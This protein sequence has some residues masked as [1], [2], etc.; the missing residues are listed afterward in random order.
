[1]T[2]IRDDSDLEGPRSGDARAASQDQAG[3][4]A[5]LPRHIAPETI[6]G[7]SASR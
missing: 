1:M 5:S 7:A 3:D 2:M 6:D 4:R